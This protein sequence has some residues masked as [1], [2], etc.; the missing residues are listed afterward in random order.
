[1]QIHRFSAVCVMLRESVM[2]SITA[3]L[4]ILVIFNYFKSS[5]LCFICR[6][7]LINYNLVGD[8][9]DVV[10]IASWRALE[11][12]QHP[13]KLRIVR[14]RDRFVYWMNLEYWWSNLSNREAGWE[15]LSTNRWRQ[16]NWNF[17]VFVEKHS[18]ASFHL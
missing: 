7:N 1:M 14:W 16:N 11:V 6:W 9:T 8:C 15:E 18:T 2:N 17:H 5:R 12:G 10:S 4:Y 3:S 13:I